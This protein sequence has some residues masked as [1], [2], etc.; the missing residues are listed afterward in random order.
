MSRLGL[1]LPHRQHETPYSYVSRLAALNGVKFAEDFVSD[2]GLSWQAIWEGDE[3]AVRDMACLASQDPEAL[4]KCNIRRL[5]ATELIIGGEIFPSTNLLRTSL[6]VCP[7][8]LRED[9]QKYGQFGPYFRVYWATSHYRVCTHHGMLL[10]TV[11]K[12]VH[13]LSAMDTWGQLSDQWAL[14]EDEAL[15]PDDIGKFKR[16]GRISCPCFFPV[17]GNGGFGFYCL[18]NLSVF[19]AESQR[20]VV[21]LPRSSGSTD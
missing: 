7:R 8:F 15:V 2:I 6:K 16:K 11:P 17:Y 4:L 20:F 13:Q 5:S 9:Q 18:G 3:A 21:E 12:G 19:G 14:I 1:T 10:L